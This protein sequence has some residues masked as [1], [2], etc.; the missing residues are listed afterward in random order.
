MKNARFEIYKDKENQ[1]R[2]RLV[3]SNG[4]IIA[5]GAGDGYHNKQDC[6]AGLKATVNAPFNI[7]SID[8][9]QIEK[10]GRKKK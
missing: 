8:E 1:W 10:R 2:W 5:C 4:N 7:V 6:I 3:S 9:E